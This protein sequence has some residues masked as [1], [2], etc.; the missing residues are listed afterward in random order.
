MN[1]AK[2]SIKDAPPDGQT[3][4]DQAYERM[5]RLI[6]DNVWPP[7]QQM[8][9][10]EIALQL[11]MSRT[12]VH[13]SLARLQNEGLIEVIPRRG[14][15]VLPVSPTDMR[16]IYEILTALECMAAELVARMRPSDEQL[17]P[18]IE[19]TNAMS[20]ALEVND[21]DA[22]A[23]ADEDFHRMLIELSGNRQLAD[24]VLN[25]WDRAHRARMFSLRLRPAPV[26]ST[27]EHMA[28]LQQLREGDAEGASR[29]FRAHRE[30][31]SAELLAI[32]ERFRLQQM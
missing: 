1:A 23:A 15:R 27:Q 3:M 4:V 14:M 13:E 28:M 19:A 6:L 5:R 18:L 10:Q 29:V 11:G 9:E 2:D 30:R 24:T 22:W 8:L 7:G 25:Y 21:L 17:Q 31:A 26:N 32:F 16:E 12:P 20:R